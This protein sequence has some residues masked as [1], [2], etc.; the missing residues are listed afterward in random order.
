M[1]ETL[2][3]LLPIFVISNEDLKIEI[4]CGAC[5]ITCER[6]KHY[7]KVSCIVDDTFI[8]TRNLKRSIADSFWKMDENRKTRILQKLLKIWINKYISRLNRIAASLG[9]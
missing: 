6:L 3:P 5:S 8:T 7:T 4:C 2:E 1:E 9:K